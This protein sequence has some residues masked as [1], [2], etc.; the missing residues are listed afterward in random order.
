[1]TNTAKILILAA[2]MS[3]CTVP[4]VYISTEEPTPLPE[5]PAEVIV[6]DGPVPYEQDGSC[7]SFHDNELVNEAYAMGFHYCLY[8][9]GMDEIV[10]CNLDVESSRS[11]CTNSDRNPVV[12][13][14]WQESPGQTYGA[15]YIPQSTSPVASVEGE[16]RPTSGGQAMFYTITFF[17]D[18]HSTCVVGG[19]TV[20]YCRVDW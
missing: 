11:I 20:Q 1:M 18:T 4:P 15:L 17:D 2:F 19:P 12:G 10:S 13:V 7:S 14:Q 6:A 9:E 8:A 5:P 16:V 3:G